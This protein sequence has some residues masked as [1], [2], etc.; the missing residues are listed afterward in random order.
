MTNSF[1]CVRG[2][3]GC[4][5]G[6]F[7]LAPLGAEWGVVHAHPSSPSWHKWAGKPKAW[8]RAGPQELLGGSF[9]L[10]VGFTQLA[11]LMSND[12]LTWCFSCPE[13]GLLPQHF[14]EERISLKPWFLP[15]PLAEQKPRNKLWSWLNCTMGWLKSES[16]PFF[17]S[18]YFF[19]IR[20][21]CEGGKAVVWC[22]GKDADSTVQFSSVA[23][24]CLTLCDPM[25][26]ST[27][28][29]PVHQKLLEFTQTHA[30][31][32]GDAIQPPHPL[33]SP[34]P[35]APNASQHQGLF[36]W[37]SSSHQVAKVVA[38]SRTASKSH[39][40]VSG[41]YP[42]IVA[43]HGYGFFLLSNYKCP[44]DSAALLL[45]PIVGVFFLHLFAN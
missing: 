5:S 42:G 6:F 16:V 21:A 37:V 15:P 20:G 32:V 31:R 4:S 18:I 29:L 25:N 30:H 34:S 45:Q 9:L 35:P 17:K 26:C 14:H 33:S 27:P 28:G 11:E 7:L 23:Q 22:W 19:H 1:R 8:R 3:S 38:D 40:I 13:W 39:F 36:H 44:K 2:V 10:V 12:F 43:Y 41:A 24:S